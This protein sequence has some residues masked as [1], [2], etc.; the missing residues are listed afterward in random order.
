L[1]ELPPSVGAPTELAEAEEMPGWIADIVKALTAG[2]ILLAFLC[3]GLPTALA[4][5]WCVSQIL[6]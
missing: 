1:A 5:C 4:V 2:P 3:G 6:F